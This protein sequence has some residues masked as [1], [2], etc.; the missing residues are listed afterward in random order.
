MRQ[1]IIKY[2]DY[3]VGCTMGAQK[4]RHVDRAQRERESEGEERRRRP[5]HPHAGRHNAMAQPNLPPQ[6]PPQQHHQSHQQ[7]QYQP[8]QPSYNNQQYH[9]PQAAGNSTV[10]PPQLM[11]HANPHHHH[12]N[13]HHNSP[14]A[15]QQ[16]PFLPPQPLP[17]H[18]AVRQGEAV[19]GQSPL[20]DMITNMV[21]LELVPHAERKATVH[22]YDITIENRVLSGGSGGDAA[23]AEAEAMAMPEVGAVEEH[24]EELPEAVRGR[25]FDEQLSSSIRAHLLPSTGPPCLPLYE[26]KGDGRLLWTAGA[27][28]SF[29][30]A[31]AAAVA[32]AVADGWVFDANA[33]T[34]TWT[35]PRRQ[36]GAADGQAVGGQIIKQLVAI[37]KATGRP[38]IQLASFDPLEQSDA[39]DMSVTACFG[40]ALRSDLT[41]VYK[42]IGRCAG[43]RRARR[44]TP[45]ARC[46]PTLCDTCPLSCCC[47]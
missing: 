19:P 20:R 6:Q 14:A 25:I 7:Q 11:Q 41:R 44:D 27:P 47:S 38:P 24:V 2:V 13:H 21:R 22:L 17:A 46:P 33:Q 1:Y 26:K 43:E 16:Q 40:L 45:A 31:D 15:Q 9:N 36:G 4:Q 12:H 39:S 35:Q 23:M 42:P 32:A 30:P 18:P 29:M 34:A 8:H 3:A 28:L 10:P 5:P 37:I